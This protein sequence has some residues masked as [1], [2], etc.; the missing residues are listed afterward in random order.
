MLMAREYRHIHTH[1]DGVSLPVGQAVQLSRHPTTSAKYS[2]SFLAALAIP[3]G[4]TLS[5]DEERKRANR[6][7]VS[8]AVPSGIP[9]VSC[10]VVVSERRNRKK[11]QVRFREVNVFEF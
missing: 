5:E 4:D 7:S 6:R 11:F 3:L 9:H 1:S 2:R 8:I 10:W